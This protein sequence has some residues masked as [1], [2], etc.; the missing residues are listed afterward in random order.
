M[1]DGAPWRTASATV[2]SQDLLT[3]AGNRLPTGSQQAYGHTGRGLRP[4]HLGNAGLGR[5][6][7]Y[8]PRD[9]LMRRASSMLLDAADLAAR[10][11]NLRTI[12]FTQVTAV[13]LAVVVWFAGPAVTVVLVAWTLAFVG[14]V[15]LG[16]SSLVDTSAT[17]CRTRGSSSPSGPTRCCCVLWRG[18]G[19]LV[20][21]AGALPLRSPRAGVPLLPHLGS[22]FHS[23]LGLVAGHGAHAHAHGRAGGGVRSCP[24]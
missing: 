24:A 13:G 3:R 23:R 18:P 11:A 2:P 10:A 22:V 1:T 8:G 19:P 7:A 4:Q 6:L 12:L 9:E 20:R 21:R 16:T 17:A 14:A 15:E 5:R